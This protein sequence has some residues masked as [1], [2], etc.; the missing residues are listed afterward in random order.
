[1]VNPFVKTVGHSNASIY[2]KYSTYK[3]D[4]GCTGIHMYM[5]VFGDQ[6]LLYLY[7]EFV[8][9]LSVLETPPVS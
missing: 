4:V 9:N 2:S 6:L 5:N 3:N 1:M 7:R 8:P